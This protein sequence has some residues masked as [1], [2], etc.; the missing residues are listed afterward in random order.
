MRKALEKKSRQLT[1][2][3]MATR[4]ALG[5]CLVLLGV[6]PAFSQDDA[7][8]RVDKESM[9]ADVKDIV[10][11]NRALREKR[12]RSVERTSVHTEPALHKEPEFSDV[13]FNPRH[14]CCKQSL[15]DL[16]RV[17]SSSKPLQTAIGLGGFISLLSKP[18][19]AVVSIFSNDWKVFGESM[20]A[21]PEITQNRV[22]HICKAELI[23]HSS[24]P[25]KE[26]WESMYEATKD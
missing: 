17:T 2:Q 20:K 1:Y 5:G 6:G 3:R 25:E 14:E 13:H 11:E 22:E 8:D 21:V 12:S 10:R 15:R 7:M 23:N 26:F 18:F 19:G 24:G 4:F 9:R 16:E